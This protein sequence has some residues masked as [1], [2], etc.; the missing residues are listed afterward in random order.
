[1][2]AIPMNHVEFLC[3]DC[4]SDGL[5]ALLRS[6]LFAEQR[7]QISDLVEHQLAVFLDHIAAE[8]DRCA[9]VVGEVEIVEIAEI[10]LDTHGWL[11][12]DI[13]VEDLCFIEI[14]GKTQP[15]LNRNLASASLFTQLSKGR[16]R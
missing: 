14:L 9:A 7:L 8:S 15:S 1:M 13:D 2:L 5:S 6:R 16:S 3:K 4:W 11:P 12:F 10:H